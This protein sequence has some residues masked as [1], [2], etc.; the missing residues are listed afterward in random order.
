MCRLA[1][2]SEN[3]LLDY[4]DAYVVTLGG[5]GSRYV[6]RDDTFV[7]DAVFTETVLDPTG[8]GDA[9]RSGVLR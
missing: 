2:L 9:F 5:E 6:G 4:V 8:A 7:V 1:E 3:N